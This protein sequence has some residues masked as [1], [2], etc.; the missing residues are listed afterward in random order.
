MQ[1]GRL[2]CPFGCP[3]GPR[4]QD[5][6][7]LNARIL[8]NPHVRQKWNEKRAFKWVKKKVKLEWDEFQVQAQQME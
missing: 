3:R 8:S 6:G 7:S 1:I 2:G 5:H 4:Q